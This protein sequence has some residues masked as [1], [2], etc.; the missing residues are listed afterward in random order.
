MKR[1]PGA[2]FIDV[3]QQGVPEPLLDRAIEVFGERVL[4]KRSTTWR[5]LDEAARAAP[6]RS[7]LI[8]HPT[9]MK[10]PLIEVGDQL[11]I[12]WNSE[13]EEEIKAAG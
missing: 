2:E 1:L 4:N 12:G 7:L 6:V 10:R 9:L 11:F 5:G 8:E 13:I 3:R